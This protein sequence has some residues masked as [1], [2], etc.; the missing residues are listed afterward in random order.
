M[1]RYAATREGDVVPLK[2]ARNPT[3]F[4]LRVGDWRVLFTR[5]SETMTVVRILHRGKAYRQSFH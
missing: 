3:V 2:G 4:R 1:D 5:D